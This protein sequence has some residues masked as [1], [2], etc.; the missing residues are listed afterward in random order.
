MPGV[1]VASVAPEAKPTRK[2][3]RRP[4]QLTEDIAPP[5]M[6]PSSG[7]PEFP[8]EMKAAGKNA[9]VILKVVIEEDGRI[10]RVQVMRGEE[11]FVSSA[12]RWAKSSRW[13]P[14]VGR[15]GE[16]LPVFKILQIPFRL[17]M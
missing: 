14:A 9:M 10:R 3:R 5:Q 11:P 16:K 7:A 6:L 17:R 12:I 4:V 2:V 8:Q 15:G 1:Q 13:K